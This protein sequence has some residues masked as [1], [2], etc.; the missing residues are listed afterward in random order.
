MSDDKKNLQFIRVGDLFAGNKLISVWASLDDPSFVKDSVHIFTVRFLDHTN[1]IRYTDYPITVNP[2]T[3]EKSIGVPVVS[4]LQF[5]EEVQRQIGAFLSNLTCVAVNSFG[6]AIAGTE[7]DE[8]DKAT[9]N[10]YQSVLKDVRC[11]FTVI[12]G[13][14]PRAEKDIDMHSFV[15]LGNRN[16]V[17][18]VYHQ[19]VDKSLLHSELN[20]D[21]LHY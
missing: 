4:G 2:N 7:P 12:E 16:T 20:G 6:Y 3:N 11:Q 15:A 10:T 1:G 5:A 18:I 13:Y 14:I 17:R 9:L 21:K 19:S 8:R